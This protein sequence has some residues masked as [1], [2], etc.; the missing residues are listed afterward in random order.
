[1]AIRMSFWCGIV[2]V[3][4]WMTQDGVSGAD[5]VQTNKYFADIV[6]IKTRIY[7]K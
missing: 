2:L 7:F 6:S 3:M 5:A 4:V 1:M